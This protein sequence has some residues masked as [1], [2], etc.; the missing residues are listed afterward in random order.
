MTISDDEKAEA[1]SRKPTDHLVRFTILSLDDTAGVLR[2]ASHRVAADHHMT[3][4]QI[5]QEGAAA[6]RSW[7]TV[8]RRTFEAEGHDLSVFERLIEQD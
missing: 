4:D 2:A 8:Y 7:L 6:L 1:P 3:E 5:R